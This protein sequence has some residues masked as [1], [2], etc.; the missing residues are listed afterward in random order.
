[1][2]DK[3]SLEAFIYVPG[4]DVLHYEG[5]QWRVNVQDT[6]LQEIFLANHGLEMDDL[7]IKPDIKEKMENF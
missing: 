5:I 1:M 3:P 2:N 7:L 6:V 4:G